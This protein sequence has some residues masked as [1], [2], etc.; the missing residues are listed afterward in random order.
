MGAPGGAPSCHGGRPPR[1][2]R[3]KQTVEA[4]VEALV[5]ATAQVFGADGPAQTTAARIAE[6]AGVSVGSPRLDAI[7]VGIEEIVAM[8][9]RDRVMYPGVAELLLLLEQ[10]PEVRGGLVQ[11]RTATAALLRAQPALLG[12]RG[13]ALVAR[14]AL[15]AVR[16]SLFRIL[17]FTPDK[18]DDPD[19]AGVLFGMVAGLLGPGAAT[20]R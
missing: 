1:Q 11:A 8:F 2:P 6:R 14:V 3:A 10:T 15:H 4:L 5:E 18:L 12:D 17:E 16:G 13:P 20:V 7:R 9:R 19:L